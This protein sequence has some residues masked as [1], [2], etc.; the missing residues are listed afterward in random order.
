MDSTM[1]NS[2]TRKKVSTRPSRPQSAPSGASSSPTDG[3]GAG[4]ASLYL[5]LFGPPAL[6]NTA[7]TY[8]QTYA[9]LRAV[10]EGAPKA[11]AHAVLDA[12]E[13]VAEQHVERSMS[14][15]GYHE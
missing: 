9:A 5:D 6:A 1:N 3:D 4:V 14:R 15:G 8:F 13:D 7:D 10:L 11:H 12:A 2:Q